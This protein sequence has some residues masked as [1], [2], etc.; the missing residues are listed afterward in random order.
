MIKIAVCDDNRE[1][2]SAIEHFL[3]KAPVSDMCCDVYSDGKHLTDY[4]RKNSDSYNIYFLDI[5]MP[6]LDGIRT[7]SEIRTRDKNA[8]IVFITDYKDYV[9]E[10]FEVLPFRFLPKPV[11]E[12]K[13]LQT[14]N[15][16][17]AHL[18]L[19]GRLFF[20]RIGYEKYQ[21]PYQE[22]VC[23]ESAGR[24]VIL[25]SKKGEYEFY[26]KLSE[27]EAQTDKNVFSRIHASY[28][29]N[30]EHIRSI[31]QGEVLMEDQSVLPVS[32]KYR[33][34]IKQSHFDFIERRCG[35]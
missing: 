25:H 33:K 16:A 24:K 23:F 3:E 35:L 19:T 29:V 28:I 7:A 11:T 34:E 27:L 4:L 30:L 12:A 8:V 6:G 31:R 32:K 5:E 14:L 18:Q 13:F 26:A 22:I 9:Y 21:L 17:L 1:A 20:F 15:E 2:S 10:V